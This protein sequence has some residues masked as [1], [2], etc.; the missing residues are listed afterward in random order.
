MSLVDFDHG[1][2][3]AVELRQFA[4]RLGV[5]SA[6]R[7]R[8][9]ELEDAIRHFLRTGTFAESPRSHQKARPAEPRDSDV[10]LRLDAPI[11][12]YTNDPAT[13]DFL[14]RE[15]KRLDPAFRR[16][17]GAMYRLN[18]WREQQMA[19]GSGLTYRRLV[20]EYVRLSRPTE[21]FRQFPHGRYVNFLSD[22]MV[23]RPGTPRREVLAAWREVKTMDCPKT[24][25]AWARLRSRY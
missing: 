13:K 21:P 6:P 2:W 7:L 20:A 10:R 24:Y 8:K 17:S 18:R 12:R 3:Y 19:G 15:A 25:R 9:D 16:R 14:H 4:Q 23:H 11:V 1:Y 22:F 5:P